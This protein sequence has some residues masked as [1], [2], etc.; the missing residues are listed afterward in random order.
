MSKDLKESWRWACGYLGKE[1]SR[2]IKQQVQRAWGG[3]CL[4]YAWTSKEARVLEQSEQGKGGRKGGQK[5][6]KGGHIT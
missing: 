4:E 2:Q 5:G 3:M 6:D 1:H